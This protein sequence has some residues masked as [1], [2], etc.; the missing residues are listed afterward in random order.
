MSDFF[1]SGTIATFHRLGPANIERL[2]EELA[3]MVRVRGVT[4]VLPCLFSELEKPA[5]QGIV[6][7]LR[8]VRY[9]R[10]IV[11]SLGPTTPEQFR[12]AQEFFSVLPQKTTLL[13]VSGPRVS[14]LLDLLR[15]RGLD[16]GPDGKG[17][18]AWLAYGY[19][20]AEGQSEVIA[21]HDC[22]IVTYSREL[23]GRLIYPVASTQLDFEFC[24]G[25]YSRVT[26]RLHG[27][28]TRLFVTP[29]IRALMMMLGPM[30]I[31]RYYDSFRYPLAGEF[32][33]MTNLA[34]LNRIPADWGLEVGVLAEIYRNCATK[35]VCQVEVCD[36][37]EHKHQELS[38]DDKSKGLHKMAIDIAK[39]IFAI[40]ESED[41]VYSR[42]FFNSLRASFRRIAQD[43]IVRY[44]GDAMING[45]VYDR[46]EEGTAVDMFTEAIRAAGDAA[47]NDPIGPPQIPNWNRVFAAIP[48]F[49]QQMLEAVRQDNSEEST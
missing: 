30:P 14:A 23:L 39:S 37:Y 35:R 4:L 2:E 46:H 48:D 49:D 27:R 13:W 3:R 11:V 22:D 7:E 18:G 24:K 21:L 41:V 43:M 44:E 31:L 16:S 40:L 25:Y 26:D 34:R 8:H 45:L 15:S 12:Y 20:I 29:L 32:S 17:R 6:Q 38:P 19:V 9:I 10:E 47:I 33:M 42:E 36:N 5:L 28:V 1:Q